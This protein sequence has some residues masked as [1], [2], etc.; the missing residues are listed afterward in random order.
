M[1]LDHYLVE[2]GLAPTRSKAQQLVKSG[3][4]TVDG[5]VVTKPAFAV[6]SQQVEVTEAMPYVSRAALKLKGFL[7]SLPFDVTGM[8]ALDIGAST[9][10][11]TQVLLEAGAAAVDAVDV[12]RDQL[13]PDIKADPRVRS[14]EQTDIRR[15][16]PDR[17][18]DVVTSDVS[19]ISL[20]HILDD[21]E[22]LAGRWI[23]L[24]FKPQFEVGRE[25]ARDRK[26]VVTDP[27]AVA[28]AM[29][30]FEAA[31]A[32]RGW[33]QRAKASAAIT[34]KEGNSETCYCFEKG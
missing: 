4:V 31:C 28:K 29:A 33:Q 6:E 30:D 34:G 32:A 27:A 13:H 3:S 19:F 16:M 22:R 24:L 18:Y 23:V 20:H 12:G 14:F 9:G 1:R 15:F 11:F 21:V 7:P 17:T 5:S 25:A 2:A 26:G 10:G 8:S